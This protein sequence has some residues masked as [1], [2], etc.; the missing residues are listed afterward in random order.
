M[1][2]A[3]AEWDGEE[4]V[5][6]YRVTIQKRVLSD[7]EEIIQDLTNGMT[8]RSL[9][10]FYWLE[11][12]LQAEFHGG[13]L[14]PPLSISLGVPDLES[15]QHEVDARLLTNWLSDVFNGVRGQGE[16][17]LASSFARSFP[18]NWQTCEAMEAFMYRANLQPIGGYV[19]YSPD[20]KSTRVGGTA[21]DKLKWDEEQQGGI[22]K[23]VINGD[24]CGLTSVCAAQDE[25]DKKVLSP[26]KPKKI[27][28]PLNRQTVS[29]KA[30]GDA[31]TLNVQ[32]S[33]V[34]PTLDYLSNKTPAQYT[35]VLQAEQELIW[36]WRTHA[37][38]VME[39]LRIVENEE[40]HIAAA[41]KRF[42]ISLSNLFAYEK[43][44]ESARLGDVKARKDLV[45]PYRK[46][47]KSTIDDVLR[48]MAKQKVE[49]CTPSLDMLSVMLSA[50]VADLSSV[51]PAV[52]AYL[53][54]LQQLA[55][56]AET[57]KFL[58][59]AKPDQAPTSTL[60]DQIQAG[61]DQVKKQL[62][63]QSGEGE[64]GE[65]KGV[66]TRLQQAEL[67]L[68]VMEK[69]VHENEAMLHEYLTRFCRTVP[70]RTARMAHGYIQTEIKQTGAMH[71]AAINTR[72]RIGVASKDAL[73]K[74]IRRHNI[75]TKEDRATEIQLVQRMVNLGCSKKFSKP[76]DGTEE[77]ERGVEINKDAENRKGELRD[78]AMELCRSRIGRW[79]SRTA[80]AIME[81]VG[82]QDANVR[83]EETTRDLRLVRKYAIGLRENVQ[84][85]MEAL[86]VLRMSILQ[87]GFGDIRHLRNDMM[88]EV[89]TLFSGAYQPIEQ[90][91]TAL[92]VRALI[93]QGITLNDPLGWRRKEDGCGGAAKFYMDTRESGTEWLLSS[94]R[95]LLKEYNHRVEAF[96][97]FVY[98]ECV[99][100]QLEKHFSQERA[101]ALAAFEKKT[102]ITSAINIATRKRMPVLVKELQVKLEAV[103]TDVSHTT[104]KEAKEA[105]L[106]S[107]AL[108]QEL[109]DLSMRQ[110]SRARETATERVIGLMTLWA[111]E[112]ENASSV[113]LDVLKRF[114]CTLELSISNDE[115]NPY[116]EASPLVSQR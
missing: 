46:L 45:M 83:V 20:G 65:G 102:D 79:D 96:E 10:D 7:D 104:V 71:S 85:C 90:P 12:A 44:V 8:F 27:N 55:M 113:E 16:W 105:H 95:E 14:L 84:R 88:S 76:D 25:T 57:V 75:E 93:E 6:K 33:F 100:I 86:E 111:K 38:S 18:V 78:A 59:E 22:L 4:S 48:I 81:A 23:W 94:L 114:D 92:N 21:S 53:G 66:Q 32:D 19:I 101:T 98:M 60:A 37:L 110:L 58:K 62:V 63:A 97:S 61:L 39:K 69:R 9:A 34:E 109:H 51:Q 68:E 112:E 40:K 107:K 50:Y 67:Q 91:K 73:S 1:H 43:E 80:M 89:Q 15:C 106:E 24:M 13:L 116:L 82:V 35:D 26:P 54:S 74:M 77:I 70:V 49:R 115:L 108:K 87:G 41:W 2:V 30:L 17:L 36:N 42:A 72:T 103:G 99:G 56:Q 29:S 64:A 31:R 5:W 47:Q 11:Q 3:P 28:L 52:Q